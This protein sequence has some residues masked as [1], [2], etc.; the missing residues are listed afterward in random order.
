MGGAAAGSGGAGGGGS[1]AGKDGS[2]G[3]ADAGIGAGADAG[4]SPASLPGLSLWLDAAKGVVGSASAVVGWKDQS[5]NQND[6]VLMEAVVDANAVNGLPAIEIANPEFSATS[7]DPSIQMAPSLGF[8]TGDFLVE[9]VATW[10]GAGTIFETTVTSPGSAFQLNTDGTYLF[11]AEV[12][13][14]VDLVEVSSRGTTPVLDGFFHLMGARRTGSADSTKL[15]VR[16][17]GALKGSATSAVYD[18]DL[19]AAATGARIVG[20][21]QP[22]IAEI[23]VVKGTI[24]ADDFARLESHLLTKYGLR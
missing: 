4:W 10:V 7:L 8:G 9:V 14:A 6:F 16:I 13:N 3:G 17:D 15:Q 24:S 21:I 12:G 23:I 18:A 1:G 2:T 22:R 11:A 19:Q 20:G 5:S